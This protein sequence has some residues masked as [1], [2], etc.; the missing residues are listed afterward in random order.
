MIQ[1]IAEQSS[2]I[3]KEHTQYH[4]KSTF[5]GED[6]GVEIGVAEGFTAKPVFLQPHFMKT[7]EAWMVREED[8]CLFL[9]QETVGE[10]IH[11]RLQF[12]KHF[13][14]FDDKFL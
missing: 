7:F 10:N 12:N 9:T 11:V 5:F 14:L 13:L 8:V 1:G 2:S 3:Q 4:I 6:S